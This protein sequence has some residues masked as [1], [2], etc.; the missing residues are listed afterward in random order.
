MIKIENISKRF[1]TE[2]V[3]QNVSL[4]FEKGKIYGLVGRNGSGKTV[5]LKMICGFIRPDEGKIT[6]NGVVLNQQREFPTNVGILIERP[7]FLPG[8]SGFQ[9]LKYLSSIKNI[10]D[11]SRIYQ[12]LKMVGLENAGNKRV[13][14][15]SM[16]MKQRLGIAQA[17]MENPYILLLDEPMNGLDD[18]GVAEM[19]ELLKK[20]CNS[21]KTV[22]FASHI[23]ED[24]QELC[25]VVYYIDAG[26]IYE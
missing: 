12:T 25:D 9:N 13:G 4:T 8:K 18:Q 26:K 21:D 10:I 7:G 1:G 6:I 20:F 17:I 14:K 16:G 22:V 3:L 5:L 11:D 15:Y 23:K 24:I 19:R 2:T